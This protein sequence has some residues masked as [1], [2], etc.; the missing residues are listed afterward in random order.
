[1]DNLKIK[2]GD[3]LIIENRCKGIPS[4]KEQKVTKLD[5]FIH[6]GDNVYSFKTGIDCRDKKFEIFKKK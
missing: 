5:A 2:V 3:T 6:C 1:M 4:R